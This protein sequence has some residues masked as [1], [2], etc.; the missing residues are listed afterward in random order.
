MGGGSAEGNTM[1]TRRFA[2]RR[3]GRDSRGAWTAALLTLIACTSTRSVTGVG[4]LRASTPA[5]E[6]TNDRFDYVVVYAIHSGGRFELGVVPAMSRRTFTLSRQQLGT[7]TVVMLGAGRRGAAMDQITLP[8]P[9][10][11]G[12]NASWTVRDGWI[13]QPIVR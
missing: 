4:S 6:V 5:V 9:L 1:N 3:C 7:G 8:L 12:G 2:A 13:D 10:L 11:A